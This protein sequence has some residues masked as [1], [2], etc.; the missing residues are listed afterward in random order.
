MCSKFAVFFDTKIEQTADVNRFV[1]SF[2]FSLNAAKCTRMIL[3]PNI[4]CSQAN[5]FS[6][7]GFNGLRN[8]FPFVHRIFQVLF[9]QLVLDINLNST[10]QIQLP[11]NNLNRPLIDQIPTYIPYQLQDQDPT[12][13]PYQPLNQNPKFI[14][15]KSLDQMPTYTTYQPLDQNPKYITYKSLDQIQTYIPN[16]LVDQN[17]NYSPYQSIVQNPTYIPNQP[18]DQNP[19]DSPYQSFHGPQHINGIQS[20]PM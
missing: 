1:R 12:Y 4:L 20:Y 5:P 8:I 19:N 2:S 13:T 15:Y 6:G 7:N 9:S 16:K 3:V 18:L 10:H 14:S 11:I 17:P